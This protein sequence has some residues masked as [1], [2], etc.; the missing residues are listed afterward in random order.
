MSNFR[1][2]PGAKIVP[3]N[4]VDGSNFSIYKKIS[5]SRTQNMYPLNDDWL[6]NFPGY[7]KAAAAT[8]QASI[9]RGQFVSNRSNVIVAVIGGGVFV[10]DTVLGFTQVLGP[11][12]LST[13]SGEVYMDENLNSQICIVDGQN[14][15]ILDLVKPYTL[16]I[17][18]GG[19]LGSTLIPGYVRFHD[20]FFLIGNALAEANGAQWWAFS[21]ATQQTISATTQLALQTKPDYALAIVPIPS[22]SSNVL[23]MGRTVCE[24]HNHIGGV[25]NYRRNQSTSIDFGVLSLGTIASN[26]KYIVWLGINESNAP[27]ILVFSGQ[28]AERISTAGI[29]NVLSQI[30]KPKQSTAFFFQENGHLFYQISFTN[31]QDNLTLCYDFST[32]KFIHLTDQNQ[33]FHPAI[34]VVRF[35]QKS[36]FLSIKNGALYELATKYTNIDEN[37]V[38]SSNALYDSTLLHAIP[39]CRVIESIRRGDSSRFITSSVVFTMAQGDDERVTGLSIAQQQPNLIVTEDDFIPPNAPIIT[40]NGDFLISETLTDYPLSP[41]ALSNY[42][43]PVQLNYRGRVDMAFSLDSGTTFSNFVPRYLNAIGNRENMITYEGLGRANDLTLQIWFWTLS[44][45]IVSNGEAQ[46]Y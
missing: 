25:Q 42:L 36:Y 28:S 31:V 17:Q 39:R 46:I 19:P 44:S 23:V 13:Q 3:L 35:N 2:T 7:K 6:V 18:T 22:Q 10:F 15:Y 30:K 20:T 29:D 11:D 16:T 38:G 41:T 9:G 4:I 27:G 45:V 5:S 40:E 1:Q 21:F 8:P 37:I 14:A 26:D 24:V 43:P 32:E 12:I 34:D 33:N